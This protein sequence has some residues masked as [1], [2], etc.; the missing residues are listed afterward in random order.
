[1]VVVV[2]RSFQELFR[3]SV[4]DKLLAQSETFDQFLQLKFLDMV[5]SLRVASR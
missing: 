3:R 1:V 4:F 2:R 5:M